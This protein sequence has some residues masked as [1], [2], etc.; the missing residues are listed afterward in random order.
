MLTKNDIKKKIQKNSGILKNYHVNRIGIF[1]SYAKGTP[2]ENSDIDLLVDFSETIT[3]FQ[4]V[5]LADSMRNI[6]N[7]G[8]DIVTLNGVKPYLKDSIM[9]EVEW[10]EGL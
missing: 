9:N 8:V 5:H 2:S 10:I 4:Y 7:S 1:G 3:L 6:L